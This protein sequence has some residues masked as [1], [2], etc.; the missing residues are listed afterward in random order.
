MFTV[1]DDALHRVA[2]DIRDQQAAFL[3]GQWQANDLAGYQLDRLRATVDYVKENSAFYGKHLAAVEPSAI[4]ADRLSEIPFTTKDDLRW[5][6]RDVFAKPLAEAWVIYETTGTTGRQVECPRDNIDS[7]T[8]N[9]ALTLYYET[10]FRH[11]R[12]DQI[13]GLCGPTQL[14]AFGDTFTEVCRNLGHTTVKIWPNAAEVSPQRAV[15]MVREL[16]VTAVY[17]TPGV[18]L[19]MAK[20]VIEAGFDPRRDCQVD[21]FM[22]TGEPAS[23]QLLE[24]IGHLWGAKA[25]NALY[26]SQETSVL[27]ATAAGG[28]LYSV[29]LL[30][31]IEVID[32]D[33]GQ[34]APKTDGVRTGELVVSSL[35]QG[36]KPL[37]RYRIGDLV[38]LRDPE[39]DGPV[40]APTLEPLGRVR[41]LIVLNGHRIAGYDLEN[42][43]LDGIRGY[44]G[45]QIGIFA[46]HGVDRLTVRLETGD[47]DVHVPDACAR[48]CQDLL[49][50]ELDIAFGP[51]P[52][53][54]TTA[55]EIGWKAARV[56]DHR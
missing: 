33:T 15:E 50:T 38:R 56:V 14:T 17:C 10:I 31:L 29:P 24:N 5:A 13:V 26:A 18:A 2:L 25:Y 42:L 46:D 30:T 49:D 37:V 8:T 20:Y 51:L 4:T 12:D 19:T 1:F 43:L 23:P 47:T 44:L 52:E 55:S 36:A 39:P 48:A 6:G 35:Y 16:P 11:L 7:L 32:P 22:L 3:A 27:G 28:A 53:V 21:V 45:Y 40:P 54:T 41:D 9:T 34:P